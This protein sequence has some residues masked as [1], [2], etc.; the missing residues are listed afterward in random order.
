MPADAHEILYEDADLNSDEMKNELWKDFE[1]REE[2]MK[3]L[4][5][6]YAPNQH[7]YN[8]SYNPI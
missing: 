7:D 4:R 5:R 2:Q 3:I 8:D 6:D 1:D